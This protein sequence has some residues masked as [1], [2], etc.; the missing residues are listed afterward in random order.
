MSQS[1][2]RIGIVAPA[3]RLTAELA[4]EVETLARSL[5]PGIALR[6]H[7]QCF[8][9][10]GHF[11]GDDSARAAAF[12]EFANDP[13]LD[14]VWFARGGY[15][16]NRIA[17]SVLGKLTPPA[18]AKLYL[19]YSDLG[20]LLAGLY[21]RGCSV[22]HGPMPADLRRAGGEAAVSRALRYLVDR[23]PDTLEPH[24]A[25]GMRAAAFNMTVLG[26]LLGTPLEP[27]LSGHVLM[28]EDV[29][30]HIYRIDRT[31]FHLTASANIRSVA[32]IRLGRVSDVPPNDPEFG[33]D[34][35][36]VTRDWCDRTGIA[37]LGRADIG[38][39]VDNKVVPFGGRV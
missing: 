16:S 14:A 22:A 27:D 37:W 15:G 12:L 8:L 7:P 39:D 33:A 32:G 20:F 6:F 26:H 10:S 19:G 24:L 17:Q 3:S 31:L 25:P 28:L 30:E 34:E 38:H 21:G 1:R 9:S 5:Y 2:T 13:G 29:S 4:R 18:R 35:E 23:A 36:A 11:A